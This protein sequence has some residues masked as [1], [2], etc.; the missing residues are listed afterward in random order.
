MSDGFPE[1]FNSQQEMLGYDRARTVF[2]EVAH[3]RPEEIIDH[4]VTTAAIWTND[5]APVDEAAYDDDMTFIVMKVKGS[6]HPSG[7]HP[8]FAGHVVV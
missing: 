6:P 2:E 8:R 4:F 7:L 3:R 1:L 5:Q